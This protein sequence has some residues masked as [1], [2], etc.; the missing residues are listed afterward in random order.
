MSTI[1]DMCKKNLDKGKQFIKTD[2]S[3]ICLDCIKLCVEIVRDPN[4]EKLVYLNQYK[5]SKLMEKE[6]A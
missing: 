6:R 5:E 2:D 4:T 1:C 3:H